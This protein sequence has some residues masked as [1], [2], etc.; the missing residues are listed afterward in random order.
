VHFD[1]IAWYGEVVEPFGVLAVEVQTAV[2]GV[3]ISS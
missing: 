2:R 1:D 3:G